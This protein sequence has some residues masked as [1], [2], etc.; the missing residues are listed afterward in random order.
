M[1]KSFLYQPNPNFSTRYI[2]PKKLFI[3]LQENYS[4]NI[5]EVGRST[6]GLPI[7][8]MNFGTGNIKVAAW[9]QMHGNESTAT[10]A[11]LDFLFSLNNNQTQLEDLKS[12]ITLDFIFM[13]NPDGSKIWTRRNI[14]NIDLNR[15]YNQEATL[16]IKVLKKFLSTGNYD[17][18]LNLHD[19]RTIFS[20]NSIHPAT[21]SF[22]SPAENSERE[23]TDTRKKAMAVIASIFNELKTDLP[24]RIGRYNDEFYPNSVGDNLTAAGTPTILF[25]GGHYED[26]YLRTTTRK[27]YTI[28]LFQALEAMINLNGSN[29]NFESYFNI[30]ENKE[31]HYDIIYRNVKLNTDFPCILDVA[32]QLREEYKGENE[33][34]FTPIV[35]EV[36]DVGKKKAWKEIDCTGRFFKS[37]K[38]FP[39]LDAV[40]NF[41]II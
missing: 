37:D 22:L 11:M 26:D 1:S 41:E 36:G 40:Q 12:E 18:A 23:V 14:L 28:A 8:A 2:S 25:E 32:V 24:S 29:E 30:P 27:F 6:N 9:S 20:T 3:Y 4:D 19:Q 39:K 34:V 31:S 5:R 16:E 38:K 21:L 15:D 17:Y 10:L 33:I 35:V 13:L 7:Y